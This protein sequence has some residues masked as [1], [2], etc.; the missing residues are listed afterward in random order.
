MLSYD[1]QDRI[2]PANPDN[3]ISVC[4]AMLVSSR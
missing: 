3:T 1:I 4:P 2:S